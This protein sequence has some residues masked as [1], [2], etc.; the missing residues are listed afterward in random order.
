MRTIYATRFARLAPLA[1][2]FA[3]GREPAPRPT[4][5]SVVLAADRIRFDD[6]QWSTP[7]NLG[8]P[9]NSAV[10]DLSPVLSPD[11]LSLYFASDRAGGGGGRDIW[12]SRRPCA[13]WDDPECAWQEPAN[14][15]PLINSSAFES[16]V[17]LSYDGHL[18]FFCSDRPGGF[19][20]AD[21]Y[22]SRRANRNDDGGWGAPVNIGSPV[23]SELSEAASAYVGRTQGG[24]AIL[25]FSRADPALGEN[26]FDIYTAK[27]TRRGMALGPVE[28]VAELS[29][30]GFSD[31]SPTV[32]SDGRELILSSARPGGIPRPP[33][34]NP[35]QDSDLWISTRSN[36]G[37]R[38][39]APV[40]MGAPVNSER[41]DVTPHFSRDGRTLVFASSRPGGLGG[42]D[43]WVTRRTRPGN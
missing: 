33:G 23:N 6:A 19:G 26:G 40:P 39:T 31:N 11:E 17:E 18:L 7:V 1:L 29:Y 15:G 22:V 14:L 4:E 16:C 5:P 28:P 8:A 32:S 21:I 43:I 41:A 35:F 2:L 25:Y 9:I 27:V 13:D 12:V 10:A 30:P 38:W 42:Q 36:I 20:P 24:P 34:T 37:D 3:C